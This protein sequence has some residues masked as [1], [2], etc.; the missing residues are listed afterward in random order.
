MKV[1]GSTLKWIALI[2]MLIDHIGAFLI[3]P[4]LGYSAFSFDFTNVAPELKTLKLIYI[5]S[6]LIGRISFPIF[7]FLIVEG[8][9]NTKDIKK[10]A[11]NLIVF[12]FISEIPFNLANSN[13]L[14]YFNHQ[15]VFFTLF[16]GLICIYFL[17]KYNEKGPIVKLIILLI[18]CVPA[19]YL[20]TDYSHFGVLAI[21]ILF[22]FHSNKK[23]QTLFGVLTFAW[24]ITAPIAFI[25]IWFYNGE[26]G[27]QNKYFFYAFYPLHLI[28]LYLIRLVI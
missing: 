15:N 16:L 26:R 23:L 25:P 19:Y 27:K 17:E 8:Y 1:K 20:N 5:I 18:T 28:I 11:L 12:A 9:L 6:R 10:Y 2:T 4:Y 22:K 21:A 7:C 24:E 14:L 3:E 13:N